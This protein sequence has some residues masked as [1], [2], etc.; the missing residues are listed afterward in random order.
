MDWLPV[1]LAA[2]DLSGIKETSADSDRLQNVVNALLA[3]MGA[4]AALI[5]V[6]AGIR[7]IFSRGEPSATVDARNAI[8]YA[9]I[10]LVVIIG[11]FAIVNF[12]LGGL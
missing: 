3:V 9:S 12:V 2:L 1:L 6:A 8:I 4:I 10:G 7:F 5:I 11:A